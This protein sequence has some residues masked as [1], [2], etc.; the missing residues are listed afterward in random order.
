MEWSESPPRK[1]RC[2][3]TYVRE[4]MLVVYEYE[5]GFNR[6]GRGFDEW[7]GIAAGGEGRVEGMKR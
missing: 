1:R 6:D 4:R 3:A 7:V 5:Q 2:S